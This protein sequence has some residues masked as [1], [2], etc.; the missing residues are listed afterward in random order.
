MGHSSEGLNHR[1]LHGDTI[2]GTVNLAP[3]KELPYTGTKWQLIQLSD[4]KY[5][6]KSMGHSTEGQNLRYLH[7]NTIAGSINLSPSSDSPYTGAVWTLES[8]RLP[9]HSQEVL[10]SKL[11]G[12]PEQYAYNTK[13]NQSVLKWFRLQEYGNNT[14]K[15]QVRWRYKHWEDALLGM[16]KLCDY[17]G[18]FDM[19]FRYEYV[20]GQLKLHLLSVSDL[21]NQDGTGIDKLQGLITKAIEIGAA[22]SGN[23]YL[24][25]AGTLF[26]FAMKDAKFNKGDVIGTAANAV[27]NALK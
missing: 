23:E 24:V 17:A 14:F 6:L 18:N 2:H 15:V 8:W 12:I 25:W 1:Y 13:F 9:F 22:I 11:E 21:Y 20:N 7:G 3:T 26:D 10:K 16:L 19:T 5:A 27:Y 4:N